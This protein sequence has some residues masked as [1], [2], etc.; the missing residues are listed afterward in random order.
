MLK[1][2]ALLLLATASLSACDDPDCDS[3]GVKR[4]VITLLD[5]PS[6]QIFRV[7]QPA[8]TIAQLAQ[9][10]TVQFAS[11][12]LTPDRASSLMGSSYDQGALDALRGPGSGGVWGVCGGAYAM[13]ESAKSFC[14]SFLNSINRQI[15][16]GTLTLDTI[17]VL[18][19]DENSAI[20]RARLTLTTPTLGG[21]WEDLDYQIDHTED[22]KTLITLGAN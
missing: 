15:A 18:K 4:Q 9:S 10:I 8:N 16:Q 13:P 11:Q 6:N 14:A 2:F 3:D 21:A 1:R 12:P 7:W 17:R 19:K 5:A 22:G 20:C